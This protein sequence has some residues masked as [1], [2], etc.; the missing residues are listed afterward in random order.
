MKAGGGAGP[1]ELKTR[2]KAFALRAI[3]VSCVK[4]ARAKRG[5]KR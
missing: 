4:N 3:L 1:P 2:T 5:G